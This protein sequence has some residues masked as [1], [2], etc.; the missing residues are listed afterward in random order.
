MRIDVTAKEQFKAPD[1]KNMFLMRLNIGDIVRAQ[2]VEL[3]PESALLIRLADGGLIRAVIVPKAVF[4]EDNSNAGNFGTDNIVTN[5]I[6]LDN[7]STGDISKGNISTGNISAG[8][9]LEL[10]V[11]R[12]DK[13]HIILEIVNKDQ[14]ADKSGSTI[15]G[16]LNQIT[17]L[18]IEHSNFLNIINSNMKIRENIHELLQAIHNNISGNTSR[19]ADN[20]TGSDAVN[21][22]GNGMSSIASSDIDNSMSYTT[23]LAVEELEYALRDSLVKPDSESIVGNLKPENLHI[24]L[25]RIKY[26]LERFLTVLNNEKEIKGE[27]IQ[28]A[29][30]AESFRQDLEFIL[31]TA[32]MSAYVEF[33]VE[34]PNCTTTAKLCIMRRKRQKHINNDNMTACLALELQNMGYLE[35]VVNLRQKT[36]YID[37]KAESA[38]MA[39]FI[40]GYYKQIYDAL[41]EKGYRLAD[42]NSHTN[43]KG[44]GNIN[45]SKYIYADNDL[46][47]LKRY[48]STKNLNIDIR[49]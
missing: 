26:A 17:H 10:K 33:P 27:F 7:T 5:N 25:Q 15:N 39:D 12:K 24:N 41:S 11:N 47:D 43:E 29:K 6:V 49:A 2:I 21:V 23:A 32:I 48:R 31:N 35:S 34:F 36:V 45:E 1:M 28:S 14:P 19:Y 8:D 40:K 42:I 37:I 16:D 18:E 44:A 46:K 13:T 3:C 30:L 4:N 22:E 20:D 38:E 9:I